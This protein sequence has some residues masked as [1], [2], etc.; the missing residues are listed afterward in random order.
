MSRHRNWSVLLGLVGIRRRVTKIIKKFK[1]FQL[2]GEIREIRMKYFAR[3]QNER[4][5]KRNFNWKYLMNLIIMADIFWMFLHE[6]KIYSQHR[7]Q[8]LNLPID[9]IFSLNNKKF[10]R[11]NCRVRW[12]NS[13]EKLRLNWIVLE[14]N[15]KKNN[16]REDFWELEAE[17]LKRIWSI[18]YWQC[19]CSR[20]R[21]FFLRLI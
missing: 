8:R 12:K 11:T 1:R 3:E 15:S 17:L 10:F 13:K 6:V 14:K 5:H 21:F 16:L 19:R 7:F 18:L 2:Q 9:W 4:W 20:F